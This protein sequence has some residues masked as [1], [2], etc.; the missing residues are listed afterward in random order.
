M[1]NLFL[2]VRGQIQQVHDLRDPCAADMP[3]PGQVGVVADVAPVHHLTLRLEA[4]LTSR[5]P[6]RD[7][8]VPLAS[9][10]PLSGSSLGSPVPQARL[11]S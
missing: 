1:Q 2:D 4:E 8:F 5:T 9:L 11:Q 10:Q 7:A 6:V 3:E